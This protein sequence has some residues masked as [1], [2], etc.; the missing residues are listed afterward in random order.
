[1]RQNR[2][3]KK[4]S[5]GACEIVKEVIDVDLC[6]LLYKDY[7]EDG[8]Q[9]VIDQTYITQPHVICTGVLYGKPSLNWV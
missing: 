7:Y 3:L 2:S 1:M 4:C 9:A 5:I 8:E 6:R